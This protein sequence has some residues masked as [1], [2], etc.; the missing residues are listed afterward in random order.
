[1]LRLQNT[2]LE[3]TDVLMAVLDYIAELD[4]YKIFALK[5]GYGNVNIY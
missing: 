5:Q 4:W 2:I 1:M 3:H